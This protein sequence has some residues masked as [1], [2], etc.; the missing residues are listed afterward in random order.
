MSVAPWILDTLL[1]VS[2]AWTAWRAL[3]APTLF[4]GVV[5]FIA[6]GLL[7]ALAWVRLDAPDI[8][9]AEAA[10]GAGLTGALLLDAVGHLEIRG[11][12]TG[13]PAPAA[14]L[15]A[16]L[17][18]SLLSASLGV[19]LLAVVL[20][21]TL[22][23][24][25]VD[26]RGLVAHELHASGATNPVTA[27]L[28]NFRAYDTLLE[29]AVLLVAVLGVL[30][31]RLAAA[32]TGARTPAPAGAVLGSLVHLVVPLMVLVS[33]YLLWAGVHQPGG[34]FQA[35][36]VLAAAGVL[37]RLSGRLPPL[38][39]PNVWVR[40]G[41]VAGFT[42]FLC[43]AAAT[44]STGSLLEYPGAAADGSIAVIESF[45]TISIGL[46]LVSL[47]VGAPAPAHEAS[48]QQEPEG[49]A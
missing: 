16:R 35:G 2:L 30:A 46:I 6:F 3:A 36:A 8:A 26:L 5:L 32:D 38:L 45:L 34:A 28:L 17:P 14:P 40:T 39:P 12:G 23:P 27:V 1:A 22:A 37:L 25:P 43:V 15:G 9:L 18:L 10:I 47:F 41:L 31:L 4:K 20:W 29:I 19:T 48:N 42:V 11:A 49:P 21:P 33:G 7:M 44:L 13:N 24:S